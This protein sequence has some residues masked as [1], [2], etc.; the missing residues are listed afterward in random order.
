MTETVKIILSCIGAFLTLISL[1]AGFLTKIL[2][3]A[4]KRK[5]AEQLTFFTEK[6]QEYVVLAEK[7][8]NYAGSE[9]KEYVTTKINQECITN[10]IKFDPVKVSEVIEEIVKITKQVNKRDKDNVEEELK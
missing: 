2:K 7:F 6:A 10:K 4:K 9:K 8:L 3:D 1:I 5:R